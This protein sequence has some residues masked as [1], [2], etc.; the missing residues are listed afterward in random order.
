M[1]RRGSLA[2]TTAALLLL[3]AAAS[4]RQANAAHALK[5]ES[6]VMPGDLTAKHAHIEGQCTK[7]HDPFATAAQIGLCL[8]CHKDVRADVDEKRGYHGQAPAVHGQ[9]C[10]SCHAEHKGRTASLIHLDRET[11]DHRLTDRPLRGAHLHVRCD[12]CHTAGKRYREAPTSCSDCHARKDPH[13]GTEGLACANC[14]EESAWK[15]V[16]FDH[17]TAAFHL[18]GRHREAH[19]DGCHKTKRFKPTPSD[20]Y[21]C[22]GHTDKHRGSFGTACQ[23]CHTPLRKWSATTF[24]HAQRTQFPL[25]GRHSRTACENCHK[26]GLAAARTPTNCY[27]C[28]ERTDAHHGQFGHA[29]EACHTPTEWRTPTFQHD[30][31]THFPLRGQHKTVRCTLCH[32]GNPREEHLDKSCITCH[33]TDDTHHGREGT[34]CDK[35]HDER[36]WSQKVLF[37]H[38]A[39]RFPLTG[40]HTGVACMR[41]HLSPTL[42]EVARECVGCHLGADVHHGGKGP[43]CETCHTAASWKVPASADRGTPSRTSVSTP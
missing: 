14:H 16:H 9:P 40:A 42:K 37:D 21:T 34:R 10:R 11:F 17:A 15:T 36:G 32:R 19:C 20:C 26:D 8:D 1:L 28:H 43:R 3:A 31:D 39:T 24:D 23:S 4:L 7:C 12:D 18:E 41:C 30:R 29:C 2:P 33:R 27:G 6:L 38:D 25:V 22:H 5:I 13:E 35:C